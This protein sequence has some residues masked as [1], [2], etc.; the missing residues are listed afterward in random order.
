M[1]AYACRDDRCV[2]VSIHVLVAAASSGILQPNIQSHVVLTGLR[3][4]S[5]AV[6]HR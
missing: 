1:G 3:V 6:V 2:A 5:L 4:V